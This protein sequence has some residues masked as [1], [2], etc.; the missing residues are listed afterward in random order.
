MKSRCTKALAWEICSEEMMLN[1]GNAL[2]VWMQASLPATF[3]LYIWEKGACLPS[4]LSP[5]CGPHLPAL[6][7]PWFLPVVS[8]SAWTFVGTTTWN[9][10]ISFLHISFRGQG[11]GEQKGGWE[12]ADCL[13][14]CKSFTRNIENSPITHG[15]GGWQIP[16]WCCAAESVVGLGLVYVVQHSAYKS[17]LPSY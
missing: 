2:Q 10:G 12:C 7:G 16:G 13:Q 9:F 5:C 8:A 4:A 1:V 14:S 17:R 15:C 11:L 6:P 3:L